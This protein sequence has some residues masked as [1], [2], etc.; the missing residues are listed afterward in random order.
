MASQKKQPEKQDDQPAGANDGGSSSAGYVLAFVNSK[1]GGQKGAVVHSA[2]SSIFATALGTDD[3]SSANSKQSKSTGLSGTVC[4]LSKVKDPASVVREHINERPNLRLLVCGGDGTICWLLD[5]VS[6]LEIADSDKIPPIAI[7][8][9]GTGNDLSRTYGWGAGFS[10]RQ[11]QARHVHKVLSAPVE[12]IDLWEITLTMPSNAVTGEIR[13]WLP[14]G[15]RRLE[16]E[17]HSGSEEKT[18]SVASSLQV[19]PENLRSIELTETSSGTADGASR[20]PAPTKSSSDIQVYRGTFCNYFSIGMTA[21]GAFEF[22]RERESHPTRFTGPLKN[23]VIYAEK[24]CGMVCG[25]CFCHPSVAG[26]IGLKV[27]RATVP[28]RRAKEGQNGN[29]GGEDEYKLEKID[30]PAHLCEVNVLNIQS[31]SGGVIRTP[32]FSRESRA[33]RN[34]GLLEIAGL[35]N[36]TSTACC[37]VFGRCVTSP[38]RRVAQSNHVELTVN[39]EGNGMPMIAQFDG[40]PLIVPPGSRIELRLKKFGGRMVNLKS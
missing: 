40:E 24:G 12:A 10:K 5:A 38:M 13:D 17:N 26:R 16:V 27:A 4:D 25:D 33:S 35:G 8:P 6:S 23:K 32:S 20:A 29:Q 9:L 36:Y 2:L 21:R 39:N 7:I 18:S 37:T 1:S 30:L 14:P 22:H 28:A 31:Y 34:D 19:T 15:L 3:S 11:I